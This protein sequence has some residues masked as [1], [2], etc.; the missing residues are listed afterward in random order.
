MATIPTN[1]RRH[2]LGLPAGSVRALLAIGTLVYSWILV[3]LMIHDP[4]TDE[5]SQTIRQESTL[6]FLYMQFLMVLI[7]AHFFSAHGFTI[8][9]DPNQRSPLWLP[10][11]TLR[12]L[13]LAGYL[14][15]LIWAYRH[16]SVFA[17][18]R[19]LDK[20]PLLLMLSIL[21]GAYA[22]GYL[23]NA[24][25]QMFHGGFTPPWLQDVQAWFS[26]LGLL[27]LGAVLVIRLV[28]NTNV[29]LENHIDVAFS[30][31]VLAGVVSF[32]FGARS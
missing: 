3:M 26:L 30:E 9:G 20:A 10:R 8:G 5:I 31:A 32:Y 4:G 11:G 16:H 18:P 2:A 7:F 24:I 12:I 22:L 6:S 25:F 29:Q 14:V 1:P 17:V 19:E 27:L 15:L 28:I 21:I 13:L 23:T